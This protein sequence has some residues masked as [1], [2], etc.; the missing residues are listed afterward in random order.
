[1]DLAFQMTAAVAVL[2]A[3]AGALWLLRR[4][5]QSGSAGRADLAVEGRVSLTAQHGLH[6]VRFEGARL[7]L[8]THPNGCAVIRSETQS[9]PGGAA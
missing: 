9:T 1:M 7:L 6:V 5:Q 8:A 4:Q 2:A 3:M